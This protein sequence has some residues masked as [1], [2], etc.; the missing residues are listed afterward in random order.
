MEKDIQKKVKTEKCTTENPGKNHFKNVEIP[1]KKGRKMRHTSNTQ[2]K[3]HA[4][5][6]QNRMLRTLWNSAK[7]EIWF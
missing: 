7:I 3:Q 1:Y 4:C 5:C 6:Q 2:L